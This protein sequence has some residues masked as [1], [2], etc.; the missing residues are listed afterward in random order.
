MKFNKLVRNYY[1][2]A[3]GDLPP[4]MED[5]P[6]LS[7]PGAR[8]LHL[9]PKDDP[10]VTAKARGKAREIEGGM[11]GVLREKLDAFRAAVSKGYDLLL[12]GV[13]SPENPIQQKAAQR[14]VSWG[15]N[16]EEAFI[17]YLMGGKI[18]RNLFS[19]ID[20]NVPDNDKMIPIFDESG[21]G[22]RLSP[23]AIARETL[24]LFLQ[25]FDEYEFPFTKNRD[26]YIEPPQKEWNETP[27]KMKVRK[28]WMQTINALRWLAGERGAD[29]SQF[30][31]EFKERQKEGYRNYFAL[32]INSTPDNW[33]IY[34]SKKT[35]KKLR[36]ITGSLEKERI[37]LLTSDAP[38]KK[39]G[40]VNTLPMRFI[41]GVPQYGDQLEAEDVSNQGGVLTGKTFLDKVGHYVIWDVIYAKYVDHAPT[42]T[43]K[44][45]T[46][47]NLQNLTISDYQLTVDPYVRRQRE[48]KI[49]QLPP[50][51][52]AEEAQP[53]AE[54]EPQA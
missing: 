43:L 12:K 10:E 49:A 39:N 28:G 44:D 46:V 11:G 6:A 33:V 42:F 40:F 26:G 17:Y 31:W 14:Y 27:E 1:T 2:E 15:M 52:R 23:S 7:A 13:Y 16:E 19:I 9:I 3:V 54:Q 53:Q 38:N 29:D 36:S 35:N 30:K 20:L 51:R 4:P 32:D 34:T 48:E 22:H 37:G 24:D 25:I 47:I 18:L 50:R 8:T 45:G 41:N 5:D 21:E